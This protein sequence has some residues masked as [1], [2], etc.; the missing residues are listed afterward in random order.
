M[1]KSKE[2]NSHSWWEIY[3]MHKEKR[4]VLEDDKRRIDDMDKWIDSV[5]SIQ[6]L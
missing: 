5:L 4:D 3:E 2:Q 1:K 6:V